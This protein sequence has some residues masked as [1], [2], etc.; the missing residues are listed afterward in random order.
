MVVTFAWGSAN[1]IIHSHNHFGC[2]RAGQKHLLFHFETV[3]NAEFFHVSNSS[4]DDICCERLV[5]T[6]TYQYQLCCFLRNV[7]L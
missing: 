7:V 5:H 3:Q 1:N 4:L 2:F 6:F